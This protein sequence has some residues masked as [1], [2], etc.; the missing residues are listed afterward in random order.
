MTDV[1]GWVPLARWM[2]APGVDLERAGQHARHCE[3]SFSWYSPDEDV[4]MH[5]A[6][7]RRAPLLIARSPYGA[8]L[9]GYLDQRAIAWLG[10]S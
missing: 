6:V 4:V 2:P 3:D 9:R 5:W 10:R 1:R 8:W 7:D